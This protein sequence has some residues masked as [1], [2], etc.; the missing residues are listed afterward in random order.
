MKKILLINFLVMYGIIG[1]AQYTI[2]DPDFAA[3]LQ[4]IVPNAMDGDTLDETHPDVTSLTVLDVN[5]IGVADLDGLQFFTALEELDCS[6]NPLSSLPNLPS[7]LLVL[8]CVSNLLDSL[9][10]LPPGLVEL[11]CGQNYLTT[12]PDLPP[13]LKILYSSMNATPTLPELPDSLIELY[14]RWSGLDSLPDLPASLEY[15]SCP[16]NYIGVLPDLPDSLK[17]LFCDHCSLDSLPELPPALTSLGCNS[18][19]LTSLPELPFTLRYFNCSNNY[20]T[21][22]PEL[23]SSLLHLQCFS[24]SQLSTLPELP[25]FLKLLYCDDTPIDC[26]PLLPNSLEELVC[27]NSGI[28]CLP[29]IPDAFDISESDLGFPLAVCNVVNTYCPINWEAIGGVVFSDDNG[30]GVFDL[31]EMPMP[32]VQV[33]GQPGNYSTGSGQNGYYVL[34]LDTGTYTVQGEEIFYHTITTPSGVFTLDSLDVDSLNIGYQLTPGIYDLIVDITGDPARPGFLNNVYL[35]VQNY[36]TEVTDAAVSLTFDS[37]QIW[38]GCSVPTDSVIGNTAYWNIT[39]NLWVVW[40]CTV[41]LETPVN[42]P[43]GT[44]ITHVLIATPQVPDQTADNNTIIF[45]GQV[46]G[47]YDP[48]DKLLHPAHM[49]PLEVQ[50]GEMI[51][52]TIRFQN[53]GTFQAERVVITDTLSADLDWGSMDFISSSHECTWFLQNGV[54]HFIF[55]P[56]FLPDSNANEPESH[57]FVKFRMQPVSTLMAG[58]QIENVANI[59][60]DFNE[61]VITDPA[62]FEVSISTD[63]SEFASSSF[64]LFPNPTNGSVTI[65]S[66][67]S[68]DLIRV[69]QLDGRMVFEKQINNKSENLDLEHLSAGT[70]IVSI[71]HENG[72]I[73]S[74]LLMLN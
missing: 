17:K 56:I 66:S 54:L 49:S 45:H 8:D 1:Q 44:P 40:N 31:G 20:L 6:E 12:I 16:Y 27:V 15:L 48:N 19:G 26:L 67:E 72:S 46:V 68:M 43:F 53:T 33:E 36:G 57:G 13:T 50:A 38:I 47:S 65:I 34:P 4:Q 41:E 7:T 59:Y 32:D 5:N 61:P 39:L 71:V 28:S 58:E 9:P 73:V 18:N 23:P 30:N 2:P 52:Y 29:N 37:D 55:D 70:Y 63:I 10:E 22:L 42:T 35:E 3:A 69:L 11:Y 14:C 24:I 64:E 60:F 51:D 74:K 25:P 62:I 21:S